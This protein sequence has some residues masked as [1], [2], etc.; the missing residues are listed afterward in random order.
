MVR[1]KGAISFHNGG[2]PIKFQFQ[3][4]TI[5]RIKAFTFAVSA[6]IFQFQNGTIKRAI[7]LLRNERI[8]PISIPKWYD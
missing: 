2:R 4:G 5:K 3:N 6:T 8:A 1:L 7:I